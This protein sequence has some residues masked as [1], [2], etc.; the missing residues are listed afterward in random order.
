MSHEVARVCA[1]REERLDIAGW[2]C[3]SL[4]FLQSFSQ[5]ISLLFF[6]AWSAV[7]YT[8]QLEGTSLVGKGKVYMNISVSAWTLNTKVYLITQF[9]LGKWVGS[10][11]PSHLILLSGGGGNADPSL[12]FFPTNIS[13]VSR[14]MRTCIARAH[15]HT[16]THTLTQVYFE[17]ISA[18]LCEWLVFLIWPYIF[19]YLN[20]CLQ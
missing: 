17:A 9:R 12:F 13:W 2:H 4:F 19:C 11:E 18:P 20:V 15:T 5:I 7:V 14:V 16:H 1:A 10:M 8:I 6:F 3:S